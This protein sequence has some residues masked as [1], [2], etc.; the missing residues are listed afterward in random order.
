[1]LKLKKLIT[2]Y[3]TISISQFDDKQLRDSFVWTAKSYRN[4]LHLSAMGVLFMIHADSEKDLDD[5]LL[6]LAEASSVDFKYTIT[7][8][9]TIL[10]EYITVYPKIDELK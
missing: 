4:E 2:M 3:A 5:R 1:M 8:R 7:Q 10:A 9:P 6:L